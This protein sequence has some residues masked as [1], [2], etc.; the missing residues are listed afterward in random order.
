MMK[1]VRVALVGFGGIARAHNTGYRN[2]TEMGAP[3][4]LVAVC[5]VNPEQFESQ[6]AINVD[7]GKSGLPANIHT[8]TDVDEMIAKEEFDV[9]DI[10]LPTYLHPEYAVKMLKAG[11]HVLSE[12]P[13]A[14]TSE[15]CDEMILTAKQENRKLMIGQCLRFSPIYLFLK[16]CIDDKRFGELKHLFMERLSAQ[17]RWGFEHWFEDDEKSGGCILDMHIHDVDMVRFLL[18]EPKAVSAIALDGETRWQVE[19]TR[20]YYDNK[21]VVINGSWDESATC[22]FKAG[23]RA[24]FEKASVLFEN[25]S[26]MVYPDEGEPY[27]AKLKSS[28]DHLTEEIRAFVDELL[29]GK[30]ESDVNPSESAK[31]SVRVVEKLRESAALGGAVVTL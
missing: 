15:G 1:T 22:K 3:V 14:L 4:E 21:L 27:A 10:C 25:G 23:Y 20:M 7:T 5:D 12:K 2:L 31:E 17:P 18:G 16:D 19:N 9:A 24:R 13:M 29:A 6:L 28:Y 26:V 30:I 11:K 8:Y